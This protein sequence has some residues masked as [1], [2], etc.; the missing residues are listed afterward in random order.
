MITKAFV[1][2]DSEGVEAAHFRHC[3]GRRGAGT[4]TQDAE[5]EVCRGRLRSDAADV[6]V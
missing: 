5:S 3:A 4:K 6:A 1:S 2:D